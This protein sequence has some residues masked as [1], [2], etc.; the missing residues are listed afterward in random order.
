MVQ[1]PGLWVPEPAVPLTGYATWGKS[2]CTLRPWFHQHEVGMPSRLAHPWK[3]RARELLL[4]GQALDELQ[5]IG[6]PQVTV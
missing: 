3:W 6:A 2:C 1:G 5:G 4:Q